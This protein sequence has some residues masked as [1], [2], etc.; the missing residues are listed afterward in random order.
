ML[1]LPDQ[2]IWDSWVADDGERFH[3]YFLQAPR[4][5]GDPTLRHAAARIGH[6]TSFHLVDWT[7]HG[8]A[9]GPE[10]PYQVRTDEARPA[11]DERPHSGLS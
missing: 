1:R 5:L 8:V 6:A 4:A 11:G 2:W 9:L 7:Y 10:L 3:L